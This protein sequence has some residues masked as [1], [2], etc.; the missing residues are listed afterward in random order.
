MKNLFLLFAITLLPAA[1]WAHPSLAPHEH[2]GFLNGWE[3]YVAIPAG[4]LLVF[5]IS[6]RMLKGSGVKK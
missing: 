1:L 4:L 2:H 5:F 3:L 6:K